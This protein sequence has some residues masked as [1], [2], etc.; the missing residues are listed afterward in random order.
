V[1]AVTRPG[2]V[3]P[4][5]MTDE[6]L[7]SSRVAWCVDVCTPGRAW[8]EVWQGPQH[9]YFGHDAKR[10]LQQ[11]AFATGLDTGACYGRSL[12]A[13]VLP[14]KEIVSLRVSERPCS[15]WGEGCGRM[16]RVVWRGRLWFVVCVLSCRV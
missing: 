2:C 7:G 3:S 11:A 16:R 9:I 6:A 13:A 12:T 14:S 15:S 8:A 5:Q 4:R 10:G 1:C